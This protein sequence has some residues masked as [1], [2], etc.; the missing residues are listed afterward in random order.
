M[1]EHA[2]GPRA[3]SQTATELRHRKVAAAPGAVTITASGEPNLVCGAV[4]GDN[5]AAA[6]LEDEDAWP[7]PHC[8]S[9]HGTFGTLPRSS[10]RWV[11]SSLTVLLVVTI[12]ILY[13]MQHIERRRQQ[14]K[15]ATA[16]GVPQL[17][18][19]AAVHHVDLAVSNLTRSLQFY[20][21]VLG[22]REIDIAATS[23]RMV[24]F[25]PTQLLLW[26]APQEVLDARRAAWQGRPQLALRMA[27][28]TD[29]AELIAAVHKQLPSWPALLGVV[30]CSSMDDDNNI[31]NINVNNIYN[32]NNINNITNVNNDNNSNGNSNSN[33]QGNAAGTLPEGWLVVACSGPDGEALQFWRPALDTAQR[34]ERAR[35]D[36]AAS[37]SDPRGRD[38]FE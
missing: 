19:A 5:T 35:G 9:S 10:S 33:D 1:A 17:L 20:S 23:W 28:V 31:N 14:E 32:V 11:L 34:L 29:P 7:D 38:L 6:P 15:A 4:A 21:S 18:D 2:D 25:G 30:A 26:Q 27:H 13:S 16:S 8:H 37:A 3:V 24:S 36:W 22:G 12:S